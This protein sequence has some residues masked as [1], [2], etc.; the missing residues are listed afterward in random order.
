MYIRCIICFC[1]C[2][3]GVFFLLF[4][5]S[6]NFLYNYCFMFVEV[7]HYWLKIASVQSYRMLWTGLGAQLA[8]DV[9]YSAV[10]WATLEPVRDLLISLF[11]MAEINM[12]GIFVI[13]LNLL[14][15]VQLRRRILRWVGEE[16]SASS[17]LGAN[18][19]AGFVAGSLAAAATCPLDV[20]RTRRQIEVIRFS[21][22]FKLI[23]TIDK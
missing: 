18:F 4:S 10:C 7:I 15:P 16:A 2:A 12:L 13:F 19:C 8:R 20:A 21:V 3:C 23:S 22:T 11:K 1:V 6:L 17:I 9:P 14:N 5:F